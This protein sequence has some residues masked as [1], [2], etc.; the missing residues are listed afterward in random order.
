M[1]AYEVTQG[2]F[3][4][5][6]GRNTAFFSNKWLTN[7]KLVGLDG[8]RFPVDGVSWNQAVEFCRRL[9][10]LPAERNAKRAYRLPT[11]A[12]WEYA[13]RAGTRS[14]FHCG[15]SLNAKQANFHGNLPLGDAEK[16]IFLNRTT[17]VGS[18]EPNAFGLFDMHGNLNEWCWDRFSRD[19]YGRSPVDDP[20]GPETGTP[21]VIRG[22]DWYSDGRDCRSAFRYADIP[23]GT[24]YAIGF[25][26]VCE[27]GDDRSPVFAKIIEPAKSKPVTKLGAGKVN[28]TAGEDWPRWRGPRGDGTW[29]GPRLAPSWPE[30]GLIRVW[31]HAIGGGYGGVAAAEGR[32]F[33]MDRQVGRVS[34]LSTSTGGLE[35]L[36]VHPTKSDEVERILCFDAVNGKP[37]W[38]HAVNVDYADVAYGNGPRAT[39]TVHRGRVYSLG[40]TG[41]L[42]CLESTTG[43]VLWSHD[44]RRDFGAKVPGWGLSASPVVFRQLLIV[45]AGAESNG[46]YLAFDLDT[47]E[48]R[49]RSL[50]DPAGYATPLLIDHN[51]T[52]Q[53]AC[54]TPTHIR[55]LDPH[56]GELL[57]SEPFTVNYGTSIASPLFA[58][59]MLLV[60][61]YYEGAVALRLA[62]SSR[63]ELAWKEGRD[64]RALMAQPL[65]RDGYAYLL[66]KRHG[67]TCFEFATGKKLWDDDNRLTPKGRNPQATLVWAGDEDRVLALNS[68]GDLV[69]GRVRPDG[70]VETARANILGSTWAH[71]AY[72]GNCV[73]ARS[74]S[75]LVCVL[76][77]TD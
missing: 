10:E 44:L 21:R 50:P 55:G 32:V 38:T 11:E 9:S 54:W 39:P 42:R 36:E 24:F 76:L 15:N 70:Y 59:N 65:Y 1:G 28:L 13:C 52:T 73:Y 5:V 53:L 31:Q 2:E 72:A 25:R 71:P 45:H 22:G 56:T 58:E 66:D 75:E 16:G 57:W 8:E 34:N 4:Q 69:L 3:R 63:A 43:K 62:N 60:S 64:L 27:I 47:G 46:C 17:T 14:V 6:M 68:E 23:D 35:A 29:R 26:V 40:A 20:T 7:K 77:P 18:Y 12:E 33:V 30:A 51:G 37:L 74:D 67:L 49:W 61:S 48:L 19:Y 41:H